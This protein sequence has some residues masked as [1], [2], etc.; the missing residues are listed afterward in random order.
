ML[1]YI[2]NYV[3]KND[4]NIRGLYSLFDKYQI[5]LFY[6][7]K[8]F[9]RFLVVAF[10]HFNLKKIVIFIVGINTKERSLCQGISVHLVCVCVCVCAR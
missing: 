10:K 2:L 5:H 7:L 6:Y 9:R 3:L 1:I 8:I 4:F